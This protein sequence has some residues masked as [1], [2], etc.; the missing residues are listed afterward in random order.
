MRR[1]HVVG[2]GTTDLGYR[3]WPP[4]PP[5][6]RMRACRWDQSLIGGWTAASARLRLQLLLARLWPCQWSHLFPRHRCA[7]RRA[8]SRRCTGSEKF[9]FPEFRDSPGKAWQWREW[10]CDFFAHGNQRAGYMT[11]GLERA[12]RL[13]ASCVA[14]CLFDRWARRR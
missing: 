2:E 11:C 6:G 13:Y 9:T 3:Q 1:L 12:S 5:Q 8:A 7:M 14:V 4:V 10:R